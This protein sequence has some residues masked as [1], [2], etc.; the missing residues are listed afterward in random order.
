[1]Q[2]VPMVS[3]CEAVSC[4]SIDKFLAGDTSQQS[5]ERRQSGFQK[6]YQWTVDD[7]AF[8]CAGP[9]K[10]HYVEPSCYNSSR[11][12]QSWKEGHSS[13]DDCQYV[14]TARSQFLSYVCA[15]SCLGVLR[16]W[17]PSEADRKLSR[18]NWTP[19][20]CWLDKKEILAECKGSH[21]ENLVIATL[22]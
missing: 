16:L 7:T 17:F 21:R 11:A 9:S 6:S 5:H 3:C 8:S 4:S 15:G 10:N 13:F 20:W 19:Y 18:L 22:I 12:I 2:S 14:Q 1:M